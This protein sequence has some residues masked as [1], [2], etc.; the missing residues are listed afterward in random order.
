MT[1]VDDSGNESGLSTEDSATPSEPPPDLHGL[2]LGSGSA[3]VTF[4]DPAK[5]DLAQFTIETWFK[6]TGTGTPITQTGTDG[7]TNAVPLM[8]HGS[9]QSDGSN[10]DANWML[11]IDDDTDVLGADFEDMA[12]GLNHPVVGTTPIVNNLWYHAA[13]T[14][15]GSTWRLYLNGNLEATL[16]VGQAVRSDSIQH[17]GLGVFLTSTGGASGH[18]T[19]V[20][21][22]ARVWNYARSQAEIA[23]SINTELTSGTGLVARWGMNQSS[24]TAVGDS[25]A[26]P[27]NGTITGTGSAWVTP[28]APFNIVINTPPNLPTL[29][30]PPD[31]AANLPVPVTL[32]V[33]ASDP[34]G[35][36]VDV[37]FYGRPTS[38]S[39][40]GDPFTLVVLPDTQFYSES[41][42]AT[43]TAQTQW[44]VNQRVA[45]N[46]AFVTHLG[47]IVNVA[48]TESQW[49]N[50]DTAMSLL[51]GQ[52][53]YG[54]GP[55]NHDLTDNP[56]G[57]HFNAHFPASRYSGQPWYGG[58]Y[59]SDNL[60]SWQ[61]F[62]GSGMQFLM[63]HLA[64][65]ATTSVPTAAVLAW[66][67]SVIDAHPGY[68]V[69]LTTH[70]YL[71][72]SGTRDS[73]GEGIW[74][75]LV[76]DNC[77]IDLVLS[78]HYT[79]AARATSTNS[80][81][82]PVLEVLQD[83]QGLANGGS[84]YLRYFEFQP[85]T[86][87]IDVFTYSPTLGTFRTGVDQ[88]TLAYDMSGAGSFAKIGTTQTVASGGTASVVW[89]GPTGLGQ[90]WY[91]TVSDSSATTEGP[92]WTFSIVPDLT[93]PAAP[94]GLSATPGVLQ[95]SLN[96]NDNG[97]SDLA[98]YNVYRSLTSPVTLGTPLNGALL[99]SSDYLDTAVAGG[100]PY[101]YRVTAVDDSGNES[102]LSSQATATPTSPPAGAYGLDMGSG[103]GYVSFGDPAK[104]DL[105]Q[106]TIET[107]FKR[108]GA[109]VAYQTSGGTGGI[110]NALPLVT[111]GASDSD[112]SAIDANWM[113]VIDDGTDAIAA[114]FEDMTAGEN[115]A[116]VGT[117]PILNNV[118][119]H[120]AATYDG[121][122]WR[123]YLNGDLEATL[124][125]GATPR[126]DS[127]CLAG[128]G[129]FLPTSG[130]PLGHFQ[131]V[132]DEAR[133]WNYARSQAEIVG[134]I[135]DELTSGTGL[136]ARWGMSESVGTVVG[137][138]IAPSAN[139]N[140]IGSGVSRVAGAP[141]NL[142][143]NTPPNL[144]VLVSPPD[145]A[146]GVSA[147][148][149]LSVTASDPDGG[150]V[151]VDFF[152]RATSGSG[153]P[154]TLV[155]LPDT[156][157]Y[158][159]SYPATFTAQTQWIVNQ[160]AARNIVFV[161]HMGDLVDDDVESQWVNAD[162]S[163]DLLD[164]QVPYGVL[165]GNHDLDD[166]GTKYNNHFGPSRF[167][168]E[169][170]YGGYYGSTN[171]NNWETFEGS[172]MQF[173]ILHLQYAPS[174]AVLAWA[175]GVI[176]A[177]P[178][179]RVIVSTHD[180]LNTDGTRDTNGNAIWNGLVEDNCSISLVLAGHNH[181]AARRS[182]ANSCG[183]TVHQ[184]MQ[185]Y[186][187]L[188]NGGNGY[189]RYY[190]FYPESDQ[191]DAYTYSPTL[192]TF[193]TGADQFSFTYDMG[194]GPWAQIGTT[195]TV[196]SG[197]TAG[198]QWSGISGYGFEWY[199]A[200]SDSS[201]T[202]EGPHWTFSVP[203]TI[204]PVVA[205]HADISVE[206]TGP[207]GAVVTFTP[208][209]ASD[210]DP[211]SPVVTCAP[212]SGSLFPIGDTTVTC[213]ATDAAGNPG[214]STFT[215]TVYESGA[216]GLDLGQR[217]GLRDLR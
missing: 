26:T 8:N 190:E 164:G 133:V 13:A 92:H 69:I 182:D 130:T 212:A 217:V 196:A 206:A 40:S 143:V 160:L 34:D 15:D 120:A 203:D 165:P 154:F 145:G 205:T 11:V 29:V 104:L 163:M 121:T 106:F 215:V 83:Y 56:M 51:D 134:D 99:A 177:H 42:P 132:L 84:G 81:S 95:V 170:W 208:P 80:C 131:G 58:H 77:A 22:E 185:N 54:M 118:W 207:S 101:Y 30:A 146:T 50:A 191:V 102:G 152:G 88:F 94:A 39:G 147:P 78:G 159:E 216:Y 169:S 128:L 100:T 98:G 12:S 27:A 10:V 59:G 193:R 35:G 90:E 107:W 6:R 49:V 85:A 3:Y 76:R 67:E 140:I 110:A 157:F 211:P 96:W 87:E 195:Q 126:S 116:V 180:Y 19:G 144:P 171:M 209:T 79:G 113:L 20:L 138:S 25:L 91:A 108:T 122:T 62:E 82:E 53:P 55:G 202:T 52:V 7:I 44:I 1:A 183:D 61:T 168:G 66:A 210:D 21:D 188:A 142:V 201:A 167:A 173:L 48:T 64:N 68:R 14:Y 153:E 181:A 93:A 97:E 17:S 141:F 5:L 178:G 4:G 155:V 71:N 38:G 199:A 187:E 45:R 204:P 63:L 65:N 186:Q 156:Q 149:T 74:T 37:D 176:D 18:F 135:N 73:V 41:Y 198:V 214:S 114:D 75:G 32:S 174:A 43:F 127:T 16:Y 31:G 151:E 111:H 129:A 139:G 47:D 115:H 197:G 24:G 72:T 28:G 125:V 36:N 137:D 109:G 192:G 175:D 60:N 124:V 2:D 166:G 189:L 33:I 172:G 117:T 123:L 179:Y 112:G 162:N 105:G 136:V 46:I 150:N 23:A 200:V 158:S 9:P 184:I 103:S 89:P 86:D 194:G 148:V 213:S 70:D 161:T 57:S 119:Y